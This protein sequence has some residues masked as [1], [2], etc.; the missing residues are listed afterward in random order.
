MRWVT[1]GGIAA[2]LA[3]TAG[4]LVMN[5]TSQTV[6]AAEALTQAAQTSKSYKGWVHTRNTVAGEDPNNYCVTHFNN[7][8]GAWVSEV[9]SDGAL[10][11][12][13][14]VPAEKEEVKYDSKTGEIRMGEVYANFAVEWKKI[15]QQMPLTITEELKNS[16]TA[17]IRETREG[18]LNRFDLIPST[19]ME[20]TRDHDPANDQPQQATTWADA[21]TNLIQKIQ[22]TTAGKI[23]TCTYT[24][25]NPEIRDI[26]D[27][28]VPRNAKVLDSRPTQA[29]DELFARLEQRFQNGFGDFVAV[30][31]ETQEGD[32]GKLEQ[33]HGAV[34]LYATA[35]KAWLME[36]FLFGD[37][38]DVQGK[39]TVHRP[40][41]PP[42]WPTPALNDVLAAVKDWNGGKGW[43]PSEYA[44]SD[45][46]KAWADMG[47]GPKT[48]Q[49]EEASFYR[50]HYTLPGH[51]WRTREA[52]GLFGADG[53]A[54]LL[55]DKDRPTL[56]AL[57]TEQMTNGRDMKW[58]KDAST[59]WIDPARNDVP[60][61]TLLQIYQPVVEAGNSPPRIENEI[62]TIR[63]RFEKTGNGT[64]YPSEWRTSFTQ[65]GQTES[66]SGEQNHLQVWGGKTL[67]PEWFN[68][69]PPPAH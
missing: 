44:V 39:V 56:I 26:Y 9:H 1:T 54:S 41:L 11:V 19:E 20:K 58:Q 45:G 43:A 66:V 65:H 31:T 50:K 18:D 10:E 14:Y 38:T 60:V 35:G 21:R 46:V 25:G 24:Y 51:L 7:E 40:A 42:G 12:E 36:R 67:P 5:A 13:M 34:S 4:L 59:Y 57:R 49:G 8:T 30:E 28:G 64:W 2:A 33:G 69:P 47:P 32:D 22:V 68:P 48:L 62:H 37:R 15:V 3:L 16:A 61:E 52:I 63:T 55:A 6:T 27:V 53:K 17:K 23:E 29:V